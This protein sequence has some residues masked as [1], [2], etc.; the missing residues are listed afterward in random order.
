MSLAVMVFFF[1]FSVPICLENQGEE[2][3]SLGL[4]ARDILLPDVGDQASHSVVPAIHAQI[5]SASS[6]RDVRKSECRTVAKH[7]APALNRSGINVASANVSFANILGDD[8]Q[9]LS[10]PI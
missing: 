9:Q 4:E 10:G 6:F 3:N 1:F 2:R 7:G 5:R 8:A